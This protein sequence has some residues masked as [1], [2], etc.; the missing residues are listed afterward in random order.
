M[1]I[2]RLY[3][4]QGIMERLKPEYMS[5]SYLP[6][7]GNKPSRFDDDEELGIREN[8]LEMYQVFSKR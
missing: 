2:S 6:S 5:S 8:L 3:D 1:E 4:E 7:E